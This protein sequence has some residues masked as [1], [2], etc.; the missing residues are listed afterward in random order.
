MVK[1][2]CS[3]FIIWVALLLLISGCGGGNGGGSGTGGSGTLTPTLSINIFDRNNGQSLTG[4]TMN[5][6]ETSQNDIV[7]NSSYQNTFNSGVYTL[8]ISKN[9]YIAKGIIFNLTADLTLNVYLSP[10]SNNNYEN[11][12][13]TVKLDNNNYTNPFNIYRGSS[14]YAECEANDITDA[15][16]RFSLQSVFGDEIVVS[17][18][19]RKLG[20]PVE[21]DKI[22]YL[23]INQ[24][25]LRSGL[26]LTLPTIPTLYSGT[27]PG[28]GIGVSIET[29]VVKQ[30]EGYYLA[31]QKDT[32][33]SFS[34]G[35]GLLE[36]DT[37]TL[38]SYK[39]VNEIGYFSRTN[40]GGS[41]GTNINIQYPSEVADYLVIENA[42]NYQFDFTPVGF[43]NYY[44]VY[45]NQRVNGVWTTP[46]KTAVL[47]GA[48]VKVPKSLFDSSADSTFVYVRAVKLDGFNSNLIYNGNYTNLNCSFTEKET[49]L[50][51]GALNN[52]INANQ[53]VGSFKVKSAIQYKPKSN[54]LFFE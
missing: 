26:T 27:K 37:V 11:I 51:F 38:E 42:D 13:G 22:G 5:I 25:D 18:Y 43:A 44:E 35:I 47:S 2:K 8:Y 39:N 33:T 7:L 16:G 20:N 3:F 45:A 21:I 28:G 29:L 41:G 6:L 23:K 48:S 9:G 32:G 34:F 49:S 31:M 17:A 40:V 36:G 53:Y 15:Q 46:F 4:A 1:R 19:S 14:F 52:S 54:K 10:L 30:Q 50:I 24:G 12:S